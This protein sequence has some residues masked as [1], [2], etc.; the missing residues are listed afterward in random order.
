MQRQLAK[1]LE[2]RD[3]T[4]LC[5]WLGRGQPVAPDEAR[6]IAAALARGDMRRKRGL[7]PMPKSD[8]KLWAVLDAYRKKCDSGVSVKVAEQL[9]YSEFG[10]GK[11]T[12]SD[13][14]KY[15]ILG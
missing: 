13:L 15:K 4:R 7:K 5:E 6:E 1:I 12:Y 2:Q 3:L 8:E 9:A 14:R 10:G 11:V